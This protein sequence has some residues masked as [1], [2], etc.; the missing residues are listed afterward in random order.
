MKALLA[1]VL[2]IFLTV[3]GLLGQN[4]YL[5]PEMKY[6]PYKVGFKVFHEYDYSR[7][8]ERN[9]SS[10][11]SGDKT[12]IARPIQITVW[13][14]AA[15]KESEEPMGYNS[16]IH[17]MATETDFE[18]NGD[19]MT[20]PYIRE[21]LYEDPFIDQK[22]LEI[23]LKSKTKAFYGA[24]PKAGSFPVIVNAPGGFGPSF[25]NSTLFEFLASYG[26]I[27]A[28]LPHIQIKHAP[29]AKKGRFQFGPWTFEPYAR[30]LEY[31]IGFMHH[32]P[33]A[34][35]D[36]LGAMGFSLGSAALVTVLSR[37]IQI[38]AAASLDGW[39]DE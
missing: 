37:N 36:R 8:I 21:R 31:V 15:I 10:A 14:P 26:F 5:E 20:H 2:L 34:D 12:E 1:F 28:S 7:T 16:Y 24:A 22:Q 13:Y 23:A 25:E 3:T 11:L 27:V 35:M 9:A 33:H 30:D 17:L 4:R 19:P 29:V 18:F 39:H 32:F 6:G 38:K